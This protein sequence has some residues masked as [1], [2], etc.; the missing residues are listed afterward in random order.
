M[1]FLPIFAFRHLLHF[2]H[3]YNNVYP[4]SSIFSIIFLKIFKSITKVQHSKKRGENKKLWCQMDTI[5]MSHHW[6][7]FIQHTSQQLIFKLASIGCYIFI[8]NNHKIYRE[9]FL[10]PW[11]NH[12][13]SQENLKLSLARIKIEEIIREIL[14]DE[15]LQPLRAFTL[16]NEWWCC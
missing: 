2:G 12:K 9:I 16:G 15:F 11:I 8:T 4:K 14:D 10:K 5:G 1:C 6:M 3:S 7:P 13:Y